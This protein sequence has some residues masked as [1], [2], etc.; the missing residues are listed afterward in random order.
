MDNFI[1]RRT[2]LAAC[3]GTSLV[4][5]QSKT[6]PV[7]LEL[8][9]VRDELNKDLFATVT[10][11]AKLG[12]EIVEFYSPY[13]GWTVDYA[14]QV[15]KL[16]DDLGIECRSLHSPR[17]AFEADGRAKAIELN[18]I[19]GSTSVVMASPGGRFEDADG[20]KSV[21]ELLSEAHQQF[22]TAGIRAGYH[23]HQLEWK[24]VDGDRHGMDI[25]AGGTPDGVT[26]QLDV[27]TCVEMG[28]DPVAWI[29]AHPGRIRSIH[30][31]DWAPGSE[32]DGKEYRVLVGEG[33]SPWREII[34]AAESVGG[35]EYYLI[36][37]EGSR[38]SSLETAKRCLATWKALRS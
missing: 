35:V 38:F 30:C 23:N 22:E 5:A 9:S 37:Q 6:I 16:L 19:L 26:L 13:F 12:Y 21:A 15:R 27:G 8:F 17:R 24:A 7:G 32:E 31:K 4:G 34:E 28:V 10:A 36:E 29:K 18:K 33:A 11:V 3:A 14:K 25:L 1:S 2:L 20:W